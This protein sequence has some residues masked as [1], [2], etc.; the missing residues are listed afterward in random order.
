MSVNIG[1]AIYTKLTTDQSAGTLYSDLG[2]RIYHG[3]RPQAAGQL[4]PLLV[5]SVIT[6]GVQGFYGSV[7]GKEA[8]IQFDLYA[9][10]STGPA[11]LGAI[12]TKLFALLDRAALS[13][14]G[15]DRTVLTCQDEGGYSVDG[16]FDRIT[17]QWLARATA[18]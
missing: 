10:R 5:W 16:D 6:V 8:I 17:S 18:F 15:H 3:E 12:N 4:Y 14:A 1:I 2:G 7:D 13:T 9:K 11:A